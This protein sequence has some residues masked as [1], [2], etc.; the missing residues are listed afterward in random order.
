M[1][2][3]FLFL[4]ALLFA[5]C[6]SDIEMKAETTSANHG[7]TLVAYYSYTG[8]CR[9]IVTELTKQIEADVVEITPVDKSQKYEENGYAIGTALLNAIKANPNDASSYPAID[10]V[11]VSL[12]DYQNIIVVTPL[13]W[14]QMAAIMQTYLFGAGSQMAG[15]SFSMIVSSASSGISGVVSDAK[16][17][18]PEASWMGDALWINNSNRRNTASLIEEW[19]K[20]LNFG[21][22]LNYFHPSGF[23]GGVFAAE[24][25]GYGVNFGKTFSF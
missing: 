23:H 6:S 5:C 16:R 24:K 20:T 15:K 2:Q 18:V 19:L 25:V 8:N 1:K 14:S 9:S 4:T 11:T 17:L 22:M 21:F 3:I 7:K 12:S 10:P 13:W